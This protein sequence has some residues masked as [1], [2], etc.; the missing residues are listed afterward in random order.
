MDS[1]VPHCGTMLGS[2]R[3][4]P[5]KMA[6]WNIPAIIIR[7]SARKHEH[8]TGTTYTYPNTD[9]KNSADAVISSDITS[10]SKTTKDIVIEL[11]GSTPV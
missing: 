7:N 9:A 8:V 3:L 6:V 2:N 10:I 11:N 5:L 4:Y 1:H